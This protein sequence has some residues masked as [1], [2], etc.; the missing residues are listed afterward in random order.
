M[1]FIVNLYNSWSKTYSM[2]FSQRFFRNTVNAAVIKEL[3]GSFLPFSCLLIV[4]LEISLKYINFKVVTTNVPSA[5]K[6][7][8]LLCDSLCSNQ[9]RFD[10]ATA[11]QIHSSAYR[12]IQN[13]L[14]KACYL[15]ILRQAIIDAFI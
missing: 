5:G 3:S 14:S 7:T 4:E 15:S 9:F 2:W 1:P 10:N 12:N 11:A 8:I 13:T 6:S